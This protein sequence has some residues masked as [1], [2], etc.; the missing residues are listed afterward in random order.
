MDTNQDINTVSWPS[1]L[2][3]ALNAG[4]KKPASYCMKRVLLSGYNPGTTE[5]R[6]I[7]VFPLGG[8]VRKKQISTLSLFSYRKY[9]LA[10]G[11]I[12]HL[13]HGQVDG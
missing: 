11:F 4:S 1:V 9:D 8:A 7:G 10:A 6:S 5:F 13:C 2:D 12:N 3:R